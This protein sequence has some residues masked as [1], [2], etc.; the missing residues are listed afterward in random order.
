MSES[1]KEVLLMISCLAVSLNASLLML[2]L[3]QKSDNSFKRNLS[4]KCKKCSFNGRFQL[5]PNWLNS[6]PTA[7]YKRILL[8]AR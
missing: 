2:Q 7:A 5:A 8:A 6:L 4:H 1:H 3:L